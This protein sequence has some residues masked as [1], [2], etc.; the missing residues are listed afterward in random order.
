[1]I[2]DLP[3]GV[4]QWRSVISRYI[5]HYTPRPAP[6]S[7][8]RLAPLIRKIVK[9]A[10]PL[11]PY[12][13]REL[14]GPLAR[15]AVFADGQGLPATAECWLGREVIERFVLVGCPAAGQATRG[16]YRS[17]LLRLREAVI[18]PELAT[19]RPVK[20]S[21]S[22][23]P[24]P[25]TRTETAALWS[26]A[27]AQPTAELRHGCRT[28]LALGF[29]CG[30]DSPEVVP[31]RAHDVRPST[32]GMTT[33]AVR[34]SRSRLVVCRRPW[35]RVLA[36]A[37]EEA[38]S[39]GTA[40]YLFRPGALARAKNTV[41]NFLARASKDPSCPPLHLGRAG[42]TWLV[43]LIDEGLPLP[44]ILASAGLETPHGLTRVLP[45]LRPVP[46]DKAAALLRD[47]K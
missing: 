38:S 3:A 25:Y 19:G 37:A 21:A 41:T 39:P 2:S 23:A 5:D 30:L 35:E 8:P 44:V 12:T 43:G 1:M 22:N 40:S 46:A 11:L 34:G 18:G 20:L 4:Y 7:W 24:R 42:A 32:P 47:G 6:P 15:L 45:Y 36:E 17:R 31:L 16:N 13:A 29:G 10:E 14:L 33:V 27:L 9:D 26:W 28:L